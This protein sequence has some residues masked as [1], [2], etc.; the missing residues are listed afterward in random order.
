MRKPKRTAKTPQNPEEIFAQA[1]ERYEQRIEDQI[2]SIAGNDVTGFEPKAEESC[3]AARASAHRALDTAGVQ[4][5]NTPPSSSKL[6]G[7][8]SW[9]G[10]E[11]WLEWSLYIDWGRAWEKL[12]DRLK[13]AKEYAAMEG[14]PIELIQILFMGG[15][16]TVGPSGV[17]EGKAGF[18]YKLFYDEI[19]VLIA[20]RETPHKTFPSVMVRVPGGACLYPGAAECYE[21]ATRMIK[22]LGGIITQNRLSRV[23]ICL[24]MPGVSLDEFYKPF[25]EDR[26]I[27]RSRNDNAIVPQKGAGGM[28][29]Y[30][31]KPPLQCRIYDKLKEVEKKANPHKKLCMEFF[32]WDGVPEAAT[33]VE[34][35]IRR[36][37]LKSRGIDT[38]EDYYAMRADLIAYL[39]HDW[40]R[41]TANKVDRENKNQ[42]KARTLPL[43][44]Q[45]RKAFKKWAGEPPGKSL[46]P[47]PKEQAD[48]RNL[49]KQLVGV[50]QTAAEYQGIEI[51]TIEELLTFTK[52]STTKY[53]IKPKKRR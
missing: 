4:L 22:A 48:V 33:R 52:T 6:N 11:D 40:L 41:F 53:G 51:K 43:W 25:S 31:G 2:D 26:Y 5:S 3:T 9:I 28:T 24:D 36:E 8:D 34:F 1:L 30:F 15:R 37:A 18:A 42:S 38:V 23:D 20:E 19:T 44:N 16:A 10:A 13:K 12:N 49:L 27:C 45:V 29:L 47:L 39:A 7:M 14:A 32:R 50:G 46:D 21:K 17:R 35:E